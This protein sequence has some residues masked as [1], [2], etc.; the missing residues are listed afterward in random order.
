[1]TLYVFMFIFIDSKIKN[2]KYYF[3]FFLNTRKLSQRLVV[4]YT[5]ELFKFKIGYKMIIKLSQ[6]LLFFY[7]DY[8]K[9]VSSQ[10]I[11]N[12]FFN[13]IQFLVKHFCFVHIESQRSDHLN[14]LCDSVVL[15]MTDIMIL[16]FAFDYD[17]NISLL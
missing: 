7:S 3:D 10:N 11:Q 14:I 9:V 12:S 17:E 8:N 5:L 13:S 2:K 15:P 16:F 1:M 4:R 6:F